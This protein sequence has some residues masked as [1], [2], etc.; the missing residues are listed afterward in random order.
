MV[1]RCSWSSATEKKMFIEFDDSK[2]FMSS[3]NEERPGNDV[4]VPRHIF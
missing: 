3:Y 1:L 4:E 2:V